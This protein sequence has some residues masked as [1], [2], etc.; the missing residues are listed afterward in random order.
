MSSKNGAQAAA[1]AICLVSS[2]NPAH[3][4]TAVC[5][6]AI[7]ICRP[8]GRSKTQ[9]ATLNTDLATDAHANDRRL[10]AISSPTHT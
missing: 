6:N 10:N 8:A 3:M 2:A 7:A 1:K 9:M 5:I 4:P